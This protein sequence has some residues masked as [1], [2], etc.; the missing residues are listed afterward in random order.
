VNA[1]ISEA[2]DRSTTYSS[3]GTPGSPDGVSPASRPPS[4][5]GAWNVQAAIRQALDGN[6]VSGTA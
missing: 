1:S 6:T 2:I 4:R 5:I 3:I